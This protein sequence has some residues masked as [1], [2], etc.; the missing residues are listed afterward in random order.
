MTVAV[1]TIPTKPGTGYQRQDGRYADSESLVMLPQQTLGSGVTVGPVFEVGAKGVARL[2][3]EVSAK[4]GTSPTL[5]ATLQ[6]SPDGV[7]GW[8]T[9]GTF[10][11]RTDAAASPVAGAPAGLVM[12][13]VSST[14]TTPPTITLSGTQLQPVDLK[15]ECTT[16]GARGVA[17]IRYSVDGG[18]TWVSNVTTAA[19]I[20]VVDPNGTD[21]GLVINYANATAAV[22]N[23]W[24]A[25]TV[26]YERKVFAGLDRFARVVALIGGSNTPTM[27]A[28]VSGEVL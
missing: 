12:G 6:T 14:G 18:K 2:Q 3:L 16:L 5:D 11:Q 8:S 1:Q 17:V 23:V 24:T 9:V 13:A 22:D 7:N 10:T 27:D 15:I 20:S 26:G 28:K 19:T 21:T 4:S 25:K